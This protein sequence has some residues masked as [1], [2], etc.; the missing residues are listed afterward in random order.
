MPRI[1]D[2]PLMQYTG[3]KDKNGIEIYEGDII[4]SSYY[5]DE[6][7]DREFIHHVAYDLGSFILSTEGSNMGFGLGYEATK[8]MNPKLEVVGNIH[9]K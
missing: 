3:L 9:D 8:A 4:K 1:L 5:K 2:F 6:K 7:L